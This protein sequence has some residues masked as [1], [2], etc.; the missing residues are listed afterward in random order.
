MMIVDLNIY[1]IV[2]MNFFI[3]FILFYYCHLF[4]ME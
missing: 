1:L 3:I 2:M 4:Y